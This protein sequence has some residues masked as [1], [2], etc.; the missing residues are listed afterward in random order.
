MSLK[1]N[2]NIKNIKIFNQLIKYFDLI[3]LS[4]IFAG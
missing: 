1:D 3:K 4:I 2:G